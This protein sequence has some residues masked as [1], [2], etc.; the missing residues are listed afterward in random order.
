MKVLSI[1]HEIILKETDKN[2]LI[3]KLGGNPLKEIFKFTRV[4]I[5]EAGPAELPKVRDSRVSDRE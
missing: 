3:F 1:V 4:K 2:E 5:R